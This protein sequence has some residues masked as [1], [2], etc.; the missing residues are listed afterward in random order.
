[1]CGVIARRKSSGVIYTSALLFDT[2]RTV[3]KYRKI[4]SGV[5]NARIRFS[6]SM[7]LNLWEL[8]II[9]VW[10]D[11]LI[12]LGRSQFVCGVRFKFTFRSRNPTFSFFDFF[13]TSCPSSFA[14]SSDESSSTDESG[15]APAS[16]LTAGR[17]N[18]D[19]LFD[20]WERDNNC[21]FNFQL[22]D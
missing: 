18:S 17:R 20:T 13:L 21:L 15:V 16:A 8:F 6:Y 1:M 2:M 12:F 19:D 5:E 3:A 14:S 9:C 10:I 11:E 4:L 7:I 22:G